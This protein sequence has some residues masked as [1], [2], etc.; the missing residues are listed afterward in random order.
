[1]SFQ[2]SRATHRA[3]RSLL[4]AAAILAA[5]P[6]LAADEAAVIVSATRFAESALTKPMSVSVITADDIRASA[7]T[8]LPE[9]LSQQAGIHMQDVNGNNGISATL[10][11]RGFGASAGQNTLILLDGRRLTDMDQANVNWSSIPLGSIERIEILRGS[12][13][14]QF[15]EGAGGGVINIISRAPGKGDT[16]TASARIGSYGTRD[17]QAFVSRD[18]DGF[19]LTLSGSHFE[20]DGYRMNNR[21]RQTNAGVKTQFDYGNGSLRLGF[22]ANWMTMRLPG[23][24]QIEWALGR[25]DL[26]ADRRGTP[27]PNDD[28]ARSG[29]QFSADWRHRFGLGELAVDYTRRTREQ[30]IYSGS[31]QFARLSDMTLD[32]LSPRLRLP[33]TLLGGKASLIIGVDWQNWDYTANDALSLGLM[34]RPY[35][36]VNASQSNVGIYLQESIDFTDRFSVLLGARRERQKLAAN[37]IVDGGAACPFGFCPTGAAADVAVR[38]ESAWEVGG[39]YRLSSSWAA[40]AKAA[41]AFRFNNVDDIYETDTLGNNQFQF[42]RPQ[43]SRLAEI[44]L[45]WQTM[46]ASVKATMF[47]N[48]VQDEIHLDAFTNGIGNTNLPPSR[49]EG[50]E[51]EAS[52]QAADTLRLN[53]AATWTDARFQSGVFPGT[54]G[55]LNN[56]I[57]GKNVPLVPRQKFNFGA[58]WE[59]MAK[60]HLKASLAYVGKQ[61]MDNDEANNLGATIPAYTLINVKLER[62]VDAWTLGLAVNNLANQKYYAYAVKSQFNATRFNVFPMPERSVFASAEYRFQ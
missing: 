8:L 59:F 60:T 27:T 3:F 11:I 29:Q 34:S 12:G 13:A 50:L 49:R 51:L 37:N 25:D 40:F 55:L 5:L 4:P 24:R 36:K 7:T 28:S 45:Q 18:G 14:V 42:L 62:Q 38:R 44:G 43:T 52:W 35:S 58:D 30:W 39:R 48:D 22:D 56:V 46:Q 20:S 2:K 41:R 10:D 32:S 61:Y 23:F 1:M 16:A 57:A 53:G 9:L 21:A 31:R 54:F 17:A 33:H 26:T 6:A 15:G 19:G 47:R